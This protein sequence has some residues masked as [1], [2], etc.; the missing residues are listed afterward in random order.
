VVSWRAGKFEVEGRVAEGGD[1]PVSPARTQEGPSDENAQ[2]LEL[3]R[4]NRPELAI[5]IWERLYTHADYQSPSFAE[6]CDN[7]GHAY[8]A[9]GEFKKAEEV[10]LDCEKSFPGR[11]T[12]QLHLGNVYRDTRRAQEARERYQH[13][14]EMEGGTP[15]QRKAAE[16]SLDRLKGRP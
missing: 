16:K 5:A 1:G 13:F 10:L 9:R 15:E 8:W 12:I 6:V 3:W 11:A 7:L 14:L 2:A 4:A